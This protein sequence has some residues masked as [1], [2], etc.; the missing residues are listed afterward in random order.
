MVAVGSYFA[1][2]L[3][4]VSV[5]GGAERAVPLFNHCKEVSRITQQQVSVYGDLRGTRKL[6]I[7]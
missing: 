2:Y 4:L 5:H 3:V 1:G 6:R 7:Q